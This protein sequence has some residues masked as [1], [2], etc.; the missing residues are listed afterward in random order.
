[1]VLFLLFIAN[2]ESSELKTDSVPADLVNLDR[3]VWYVHAASCAGQ[4]L[5][6]EME[7]RKLDQCNWLASHADTFYSEQEDNLPLVV[8][9]HG[10]WSD[11][12]S[13]LRSLT[14]L[15]NRIGTLYPAGFR[16]VLWKWDS[17]RVYKSI[18][19][20]AQSKAALA[21]VTGQQLG[22]FLSQLRTTAPVTLIGFS[23]GAKTIG[24]ALNNLSGNLSGQA[25]ISEESIAEKQSVSMAAFRFNVLLVSAATDS[26]D[27]CKNGRYSPGT[28]LIDNFVNLYNPEDR[29]LRFYPR[30]YGRHGAPALGTLPICAAGM[31]EKFTGQLQSLNSNCCGKKHDFT[32]FMQCVP[33]SVLLDLIFG[34]STRIPAG[35]KKL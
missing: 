6:S 4:I 29:A 16:L 13:S 5:P 12:Q 34:V 31:S 15:L 27:F 9:V 22:I 3:D 19:K 18:R 1:M 26:H 17:E 21:D 30:L 7:F 24:T 28:E 32:A 2:T 33:Q 8:F 14:Y 20:D 23:F 10:N 11:M 35:E 25:G